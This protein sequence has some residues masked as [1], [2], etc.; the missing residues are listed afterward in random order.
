VA[1]VLVAAIGVLLGVAGTLLGQ[2]ILPA[3]VIDI[4]NGPGELVGGL[5]AWSAAL[6]ALLELQQW[7]TRHRRERDAAIAGESLVVAVELA[8]I[9]DRAFAR[10]TSP[11]GTGKSPRE[12]FKSAAKRAK[13]FQERLQKS[14][15]AVRRS[16]QMRNADSSE[17][18]VRRDAKHWASG[19]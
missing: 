5:A 18:G 4:L 7:Q 9:M 16:S 19:V 13:D 11:A 17:R 15:T 2:T 6:A 8:T 14:W 12:R 1:H 10:K 3:S